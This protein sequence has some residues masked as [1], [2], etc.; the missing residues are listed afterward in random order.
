M[1]HPTY[2]GHWQRTHFHWWNTDWSQ[3]W[4]VR[5][6]RFEFHYHRYKKPYPGW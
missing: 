5:V 1:K 4:R 3:G 2:I 6:W